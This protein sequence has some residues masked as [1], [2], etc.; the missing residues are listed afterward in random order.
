L[1][2]KCSDVL[3]VLLNRLACNALPR[4]WRPASRAD[5][6]PLNV[7]LSRGGRAITTPDDLIAALVDE[8]GAKIDINIVSRTTGLGYGVVL[9][10][11]LSRSH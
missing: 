6:L 1:Q 8:M 7:H 10:L 5:D 9:L 2:E 4:S 3:A 11:V